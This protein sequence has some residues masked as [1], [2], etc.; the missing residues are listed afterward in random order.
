MMK[1]DFNKVSEWALLDEEESSVSAGG[2]ADSTNPISAGSTA[3][4]P[5]EV[6]KVDPNAPIMVQIPYIVGK[7]SQSIFGLE[8]NIEI[9][10]VI[11]G[12]LSLGVAI[13][14][15]MALF[16]IISQKSQMIK[17]E[18]VNFNNYLNEIVVK[19]NSLI[20]N[21]LFGQSLSDLHCGTKIISSKIL[22]M[23]QN[24]KIFHSKGRLIC[25]I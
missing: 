24:M 11:I 20:F 5:E 12:S 7:D 23:V 22:I 17:I 2:P 6:T 21:L 25:S 14:F 19:F 15:L 4:A 1:M 8:E 10:Y 13:G 18:V 3:P 9:K 16:Q